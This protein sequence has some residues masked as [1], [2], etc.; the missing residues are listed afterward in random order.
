MKQF[1]PLSDITPKG[2]PM[3]HLKRNDQ[4]GYVTPAPG[5]YMRDNAATFGI[6]TGIQFNARGS[7]REP[8]AVQGRSNVYGQRWIITLDRWAQLNSA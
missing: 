2:L 3:V 6:G 7:Y 5:G 4:G 1:K 8:E